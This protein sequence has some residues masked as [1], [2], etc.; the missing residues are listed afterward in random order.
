M[1]SVAARY[2][3]Q[4]GITVPEFFEY[5]RKPGANLDSV[6]SNAEPSRFKRARPSPKGPT[7][8][9]KRDVSLKPN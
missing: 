4:M 2:A 8:A 7:R 6:K 5:I 3:E 1:A 9:A